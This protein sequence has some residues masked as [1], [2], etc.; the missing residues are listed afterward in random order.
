VIHDGG[1]AAGLNKKTGENQQ[2][3]LAQPGW[4][5]LGIILVWIDN[6]FAIPM[7]LTR[8]GFFAV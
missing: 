7:P 3:A 4:G 8:S 5:G 6:N 1:C 2:T